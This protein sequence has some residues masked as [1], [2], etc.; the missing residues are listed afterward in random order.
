MRVSIPSH[1]PTIRKLHLI[2][3]Y[4]ENT[5][6]GAPTQEIGRDQA[7]P[8]EYDI[9]FDIKVRDKLYDRKVRIDNGCGLTPLGGLG[10]DERAP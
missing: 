7:G 10:V 2:T 4:D 8:L 3:R 9:V 6:L 5:D 1:G